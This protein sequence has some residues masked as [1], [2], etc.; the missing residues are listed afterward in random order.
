MPKFEFLVTIETYGR[1]VITADDLQDAK[2]SVES[3]SDSQLRHFIEEE[4]G[5][6]ITITDEDAEFNPR[7]WRIEREI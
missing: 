1:I 3:L 6:L 4:D 2:K 7:H 5:K